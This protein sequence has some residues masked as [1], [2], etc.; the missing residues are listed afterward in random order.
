ML[1]EL[2]PMARYVA[3]PHNSLITIMFHV[4]LI[5][6][7]LFLVP[8]GSFFKQLLIWPQPGDPSIRFLVY[9]LAGCFVWIMLNVILELPHSATFYWL[10]Y[11]STAYALKMRNMPAKEEAGGSA[12]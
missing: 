2:Y 3:P 1:D 9:S 11:L 7:L 8:L 4:G 10:V 5:P 12:G 6:F